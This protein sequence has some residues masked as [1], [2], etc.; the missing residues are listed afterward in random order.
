MADAAGR[1][2][3]RAHGGGDAVS[4]RDRILQGGA[5]TRLGIVHRQPQDQAFGLSIRTGSIC[6]RR[7]WAGSRRKAFSTRPA[8]GFARERVFFEDTR[9]DKIA[10]IKAIGCEVFIDDLEEVFVDPAFP[11]GIDRILFGVIRPERPSVG[12]LAAPVGTRSADVSLRARRRPGGLAAIAERLAGAPIRS[13]APARAGGNNRLFRVETERGEPFALKTYVRQASD[14]RDRLGTEFMAR[15][16]SCIAMASPACR[17]RSPPM[18]LPAVP[19]TNGSRA[20]RPPPTGRRL[21][22]RSRCW[23]RSI[24]SVARRM[25]RACRSPPRPA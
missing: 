25:R 7:R 5:R 12:S 20:S 16:S 24:R 9:A 23:A 11:D 3:W 2:L 4:G 6:G 1:G 8:S 13:L 17:A 21:P 14:P 15:S 22:R 19:C 10:R 18:P